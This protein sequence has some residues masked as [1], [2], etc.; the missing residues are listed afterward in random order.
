[1]ARG[2]RGLG[3]RRLPACGS[4]PGHGRAGAGARPP[5]GPHHGGCRAG[6]PLCLAYVGR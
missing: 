2:G 5:A 1:M 6:S 4:A 3:R